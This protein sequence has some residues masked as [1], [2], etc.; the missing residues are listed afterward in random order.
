MTSWLDTRRVFVAILAVGLFAMAA[1]GI[2]DPD[3][4]WHLRTG[5]HMVET[6]SVPHADLYSFTRSGQP[7]V[8]HEWLSEVV[9]YAIYRTAGWGGLIFVFGTIAAATLLL[10][11]LRSPGRPY[12][13]GVMTVWGAFASVPAWGVRPQMFTFLLGSMF[14]LILER[15]DQHRGT[16]WWTVPLMLLW[17]NFHAG[18]ALGVV[19]LALFLLGGLLDVALGFESWLQAAPRLRI[20]LAVFFAC[21]LMVPLNPNGARMYWYPVETLTSRAMQNYINEWASP[22]FHQA[23][24]LPL[25]FMLLATLAALPL[26]PRRIR[27]R[28]LVLLSVAAYAALRAVRHIPIFVL[29]GVPILSKLVQAWVEQRAPRFSFPQPPPGTRKLLLNAVLLLGFVSFVVARVTQVILR[30]PKTETTSFPAAAVAF[31]STHRPPDPILNAYDWGGYFIWKLYPQY[32]VFIDG[33]ADVY[34]DSFMEEFADTYAVKND[35]RAALERWHIMT[36]V[37]PPGAPLAVV[38]RQEPA[39]KA[40]YE[41][42]QALVLERR[43]GNPWLV[44]GGRGS[45]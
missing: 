19:F 8:T 22:N 27:A 35:W 10:V 33:R 21:L 38:L 25:L 4:W 34:G 43:A 20:L 44:S 2:T 17:V 26:S 42:N 24:Y 18:Y 9:I 32:R 41:D 15:S 1:R 36:V 39:W 11:Y 31:L 28:E 37:I 29:V 6:R 16:L 5:Q 45:R 23:A 12:V 14:L 13:A 40:I 7:W 3:V 30:Q